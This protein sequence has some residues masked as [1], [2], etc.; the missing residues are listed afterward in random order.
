MQVAQPEQP[1]IINLTHLPEREF[2]EE[3]VQG[4]NNPAPHRQQRQ[5]PEDSRSR[6]DFCSR[7]E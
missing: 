6:A 7:A 3:V 1:E 5:Q 2:E 4:N